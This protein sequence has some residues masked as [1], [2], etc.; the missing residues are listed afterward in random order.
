MPLPTR[1]VVAPYTRCAIIRTEVDARGRK[2]FHDCGRPAVWWI[3]APDGESVPGGHYCDEHGRAIHDEYITKLGEDWPLVPVEHPL[4]EGQHRI[5]ITL[6][7]TGERDDVE[8]ALK[9]SIESGSIQAQISDAA[10]DLGLDEVAIVEA[11]YEV[12]RG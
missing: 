12:R 10:D 11:D 4:P 2:E 9:A 8:R 7:V 3:Y 5:V 1:H 6:V